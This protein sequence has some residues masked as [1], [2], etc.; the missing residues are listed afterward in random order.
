M[1]KRILRELR[2][3][4]IAAVDKPCQEHATA[5]I[6]K[7]HDDLDGEPYWK[8]EFSTEQRERLAETGAA[9]PDGGFPIANVGDLK[10]AIHAIGRAKNPAEAKAHIISRAKT[11]GQTE[12]L[13]DDWVSKSAGDGKTP[14]GDSIMTL[15]ELKKQLADTTA[16]LEKANAEKAEAETLAK[17]S[18]DER[19][20]LGRLADDKAKKE[21]MAMSAA[22]RK[23][24]VAKALEGD[25]I[26]KVDGTEIRKSEVGAGMFAV[27]KSQQ[28]ALAEQSDELKKA[29]EAGELARFEKRAATEFGHLPGQT[30]AKAKVLKAMEGMDEEAKTALSGILKSAE[31]MVASGFVMKGHY[32]GATIIES[33]DES[34]E[35]KLQKRAVEIRK[36]QPEL[37]EAKAYTKAMD[38][39]PDLYAQTINSANMDD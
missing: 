18:D 17:M 23:K 7:R 5:P 22:D 36:A 9:M 26:L 6:M 13:P 25:E 1:V 39:N 19:A 12:L 28:A 20:H 27:I 31:A 29:R 35:G 34:A 16:L 24:T 32:D 37:T 11:L 21:F 3:D 38:E 30:V 10:N 33:G 15:D 2:L 4:K 14:H 8:R